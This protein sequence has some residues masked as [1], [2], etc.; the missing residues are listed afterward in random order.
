MLWPNTTSITRRFSID[1]FGTPRSTLLLFSCDDKNNWQSIIDVW[2]SVIVYDGS[3]PFLQH[4][5]ML[6]GGSHGQ[7][8]EYD[9]III[10]RTAWFNE[11]V[12]CLRPRSAA[13]DT[14]LPSDF[15]SITLPSAGTLRGQ[16]AD[17]ARVTSHKDELA[18]ILQ[19][20]PI[21]SKCH[22]YFAPLCRV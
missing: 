22:G 13:C 2:A 12:G 6:E 3:Y 17:D 18:T 20:R 8:L 10:R 11:Y 21:V 15:R 14:S 4:R 7:Q 5:F 9:T 16:R 1:S 19:T